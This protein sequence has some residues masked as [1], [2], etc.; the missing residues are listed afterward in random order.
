MSKNSPP[1][2][3]FVRNKTNVNF[4][5]ESRNLPMVNHKVADPPV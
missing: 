5:F 3:I 1:L 2:H 4:I